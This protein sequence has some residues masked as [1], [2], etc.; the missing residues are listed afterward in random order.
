[1][2]DGTGRVDTVA[3][4]GEGN[5]YFFDAKNGPN[6]KPSSNQKPCIPNLRRVE[7]PHGVPVLASS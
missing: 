7:G 4:D 3:V 1:M 5:L 2:A 6:A